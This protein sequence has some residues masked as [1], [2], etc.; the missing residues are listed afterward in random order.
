MNTSAHQTNHSRNIIDADVAIIG[1]GLVGTS[2]ALELRRQQ[3][4]V[5]VLEQGWCGAQASGVNYGGVRRQGRAA[6]QLPLS[7]RAHAIWRSLEQT[8]GC[9]GEYIASGH[10]KLARSDADMQELIAYRDMAATHGLELELLEPDALRRRYPWLG[11]QARGASLCAEDGHANPRLI[12]AAFARAAEQAG[13]RL[14]QQSAVQDFHF[15]GN[16][17]LLQNSRGVRVRSRFLLNCSGAW[18]KDV[19]QHFGDTVSEQAIYPNMCVTEPLPPLMDLSLGVV[20]GAF[21]ARQVERGNVVLGGGRG[22]GNLALDATRPRTS[23]SLAALAALTEMVPALRHALVIRTWSGVEGET[24]D[25][26]PVIGPSVATPGLLHAFGF[27]GAGFQLA[28]AVGEVLAEL[29]T[30]GESSTPIEA[31]SIGRFAVQHV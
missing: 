19:A 3:R 15:D 21:Y 11:N 31:F 7:Q 18:G 8:I 22:D 16:Y 30:K 20:G 28:P 27:S 13:A 17:F 14:L 1:G 25:N 4:S 10:L 24:P 12:A 26:Q 5:V 23:S 2:A 6:C 9:D 29:V